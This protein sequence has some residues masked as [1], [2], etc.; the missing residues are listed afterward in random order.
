MEAEVATEIR[1]LQVVGGMRRAGTETWLMNVLRRIDRERIRMDFLTHT[2]EPA[3]YDDEIRDLGGRIVPCL[4]PRSPGTYSRNFARVLAEFGPYDIVHSH[5]HHFSGLVLR[6]AASRGVPVRVAHSHSDTRINDAAARVARRLY[7]GVATRTIARAAT[8]GLA[9]SE[10]AAEAL[11]GTNWRS[12]GRY[13]ILHCGVD[14][15]PFGF[16]IDRAQVRAELGIPPDAFVIGHVGRF[17]PE[18]NHAFLIEVIQAAAKIGP[19][20]YGLFVG[21]G[22]ARA[23]IEQKVAQAGI[24]D[25]VVFPGVRE[26]V[27]R[28]MQGAMDVFVFP[29]IFEGL[30]LAVVE[31]QAAGLPCVISDVIPAEAD[32][33]SELVR[34]MSVSDGPQAWAEAAVSAK[35]AITPQE[36]LRRVQ[37]SDFDIERSARALT[38]FYLECGVQAPLC[39]MGDG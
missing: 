33:A 15:E 34:R 13:R 38:E 22:R 27:P 29:S 23:E 19:N 37:E 20:V 12:D 5:M 25:R 17:D 14:L 8:H 10:P 16:K 32:V 1:V 2:T 21:D 4:S 39:S 11:F 28:L 24:G 7:T 18:K 9:A 35:A 3:H 6:I 31:A 30:G 26:D 36:S